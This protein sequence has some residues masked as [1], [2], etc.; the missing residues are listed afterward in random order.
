MWLCWSALTPWG[1]WPTAWHYKRFLNVLHREDGPPTCDDPDLLSTPEP[2]HPDS[3]LESC[4]HGGGTGD[5]TIVPEQKSPKDCDL[6]ACGQYDKDRDVV[7][8]PHS[9]GAR[10]LRNAEP[11][12]ECLDIILQDADPLL[13]DRVRHARDNLYEASRA[14]GVLGKGKPLSSCPGLKQRHLKRVRNHC[15]QGDSQ[16]FRVVPVGIDKLLETAKAVADALYSDSRTWTAR[17]MRELA[18]YGGD[19]L[20]GMGS[21][22]SQFRPSGSATPSTMGFD[23]KKQ[24]LMG[25]IVISIGWIIAIAWSFHGTI[26]ATSECT[27]V[28]LHGRRLELSLPRPW[29]VPAAIGCNSDGRRLV[30][31]DSAGTFFQDVNGSWVGPVDVCGGADVIAADFGPDEEPWVAC[32][33][34]LRPLLYSSPRSPT[35]AGL[36]AFSLDVDPPTASLAPGGIAVY[37]GRLA[38]LERGSGSFVAWHLAGFFSQPIKNE[39][40]S[41]IAVA[42]LKGRGIMLDNA[43]FVFEWDA[44]TDKWQTSS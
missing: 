35:L 26:L 41:W 25:T 42:L 10:P 31:A 29:I 4:P 32:S 27:P 5:C 7:P 33:D 28:T 30:F 9:V 16:P 22:L 23:A 14:A 20:P 17:D 15:K 2:E 18:S 34:G 19:P 44:S 24:F 39:G 13:E 21:F 3:T 6:R 1:S 12:L 8:P 11:L 36:E 37:R 40:R 43:S 38:A